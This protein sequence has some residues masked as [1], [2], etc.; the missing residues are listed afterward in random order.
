[1]LEEYSNTNNSYLENWK[2]H[3]KITGYPRNI[4]RTYFIF[5]DEVDIFYDGGI[6]INSGH[7]KLDETPIHLVPI[8][9]PE[10][11]IEKPWIDPES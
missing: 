8:L 9:M 7:P 10:I 3:D 6:R 4:D 11:E 1:V 2:V 5:P